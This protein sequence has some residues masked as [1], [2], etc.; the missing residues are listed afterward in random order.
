MIKYKKNLIID[1]NNKIIDAAKLINKNSKGFCLVSK[2]KKIVNL[3]TD[4]DIRRH[5]INKLSTNIKIDKLKKK[6]FFLYIDRY[7]Y[8]NK[9]KLHYNKSFK[10]IPILDRDKNFVGYISR[11]NLKETPLTKTYLN[12]NELKYITRCVK[13]GWISSQGDFIKKFEKKFNSI[14]KC[15]YSLACSNGTAALHLAL[16]G[17]NIKADDEVLVPNYTFAATI[18]SVIYCKAIPILVDINEDFG[19]CIENIEKKI[20]KKTKAI[21]IVHL[22]GQP[23]NI[24]KILKIAKKYNLK[25]IEDCAEAIGSY[26]KNKHVGKFGDASAFSFF[27][28]KTITTGEGGMV[29]FKKKKNF[30]LAKILRDHGMSK[31]KYWHNFIGYNYRMTNMQ[32][33]IGLA[34]L[35][36]FSIIIKKKINNAN[37][38]IKN[39]SENNNISFLKDDKFKK[40]SYWFFIIQIKD[41]KKFNILKFINFLKKNKIETRRSFYPLHAMR[42]YKSFCS[43]NDY[44]KNSIIKSKSCVLLPCWPHLKKNK[45]M[46]ICETINKFFY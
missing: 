17:M 37:Y 44:M 34:Q 35:E 3:I 40:N 1:N 5:I 12:G 25:I 2:E 10:I 29:V 18:N 8:L 24:E 9:N 22:F 6:F 26:Y 33:A 27:G 32:A 46:K 7:N 36:N 39:L 41:Y 4:G 30:I 14:I 38:Y 16:L 45:I 20:T 19:I 21:V 43:K 31:K 11:N 28:N 13:T 15:K 23:D 42:P